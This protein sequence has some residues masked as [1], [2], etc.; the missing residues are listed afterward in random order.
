MKALSPIFCAF[1]APFFGVSKDASTEATLVASF[2]ALPFFGLGADDGASAAAGAMVPSTALSGDAR[3]ALGASITSLL[4]SGSVLVLTELRIEDLR[5]GNGIG[6]FFGGGAMSSAAGMAAAERL[7]FG[8]VERCAG[9]GEGNRNRRP[10]GRKI[11]L[12]R[13]R[14]TKEEED[15]SNGIRE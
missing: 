9:G 4:T 11:R 14:D 10:V 12:G 3:K 13:A 7:R 5:L 1:E 15:R 2:L 8:M 6:V